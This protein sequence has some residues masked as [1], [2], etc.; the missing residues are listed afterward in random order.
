[1]PLLFIVYRCDCLSLPLKST[2]R[3]LQSIIQNIA[4]IVKVKGA[5]PKSFYTILKTA[6][7]VTGLSTR[8]LKS[9]LS[10]RLH[11]FFGNT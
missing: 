10:P 5:P 4:V 9:I 2:L 7:G 1:M 6:L 11:R 3:K 8:P